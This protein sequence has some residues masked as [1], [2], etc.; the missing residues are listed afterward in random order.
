MKWLQLQLKQLRSRACL[1]I[2]N[3]YFAKLVYDFTK[4]DE[5]LAKMNEKKRGDYYQAVSNWINSE[6]YKL[7]YEGELAEMYEELA[8]KTQ[9]EDVMTAYR[10]LILKIKNRDIRLREK[11]KEYLNLQTFRTNQ[12]RV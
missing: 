2:F 3:R 10:L 9:T 6:A 5:S 8:T 1:Y 4:V 12:Y 7:E 11:A